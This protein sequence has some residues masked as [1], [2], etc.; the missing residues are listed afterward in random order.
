M[1]K[2]CNILHVLSIMYEPT[3]SK[4]DKTTIGREGVKH[5]AVFKCAW[6]GVGVG[7]GWRVN[8]W[9]HNFLSDTWL[10]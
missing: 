1:M 7:W 2:K 3:L 5:Y 6:G 4:A 8:R 10:S 9:Q